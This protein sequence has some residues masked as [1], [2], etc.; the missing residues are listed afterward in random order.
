MGLDPCG[1]LVGRGHFKSST[2][3]ARISF[4]PNDILHVLRDSVDKWHAIL[5]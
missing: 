4:T 5:R 1:D 2:E 3:A